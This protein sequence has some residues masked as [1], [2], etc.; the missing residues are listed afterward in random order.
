MKIGQSRVN[1]VISNPT[2][3]PQALERGAIL[4]SVEVVAAVVPILPKK[5]KM[6]VSFADVA[7]VQTAEAGVEEK[8]LPL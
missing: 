6:R 5:K 8:W 4:G 3:I 2:P 1:V 7:S